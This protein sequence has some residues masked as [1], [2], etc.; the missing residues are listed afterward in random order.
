MSMQQMVTFALF[1]EHWFPV[2]S[3]LAEKKS[4]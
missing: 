2:K 4:F 1:N 3:F